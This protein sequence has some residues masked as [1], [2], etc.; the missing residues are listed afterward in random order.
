MPTSTDLMGF[1]MNS[2][3]A[4]AIGNDPVAVTGVGTAQV[5]AAKIK[6]EMA[7]ITT[8]GGATAAI[9]T[10]DAK[11]GT[12]YYAFNISSTAA[13]VFVPVGHNLNGS[14]NASLSIAQNKLAMFI[15][16]KKGSWASILS[17]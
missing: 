1:G 7:E 8:A 5:G 9:L 13:L 6:A 2:Y 4:E 10:S 16:Y 17:A 15:Q 11:V 12:P 14:L 3:L